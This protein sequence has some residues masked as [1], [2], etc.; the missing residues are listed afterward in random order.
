MPHCETHRTFATLATL[1]RIEVIRVCTVEGTPRGDHETHSARKKAFRRRYVVP[2][3]VYLECTQMISRALFALKS[4]HRTQ[5][6]K[7]SA[8]SMVEFGLIAPIAFLLIFGIIV[9]GLFIMNDIRISNTL[10]DVAR[11]GAICSNSNGAPLNG[12]TVQLPNGA[13]CSDSNFTSYIN[14]QLALIDNSYNWSANT[15]IA[16]YDASGAKV[17]TAMSACSAGYTLVVTTTYQ[18]QLYLPL[19][20]ILFGNPATNTATIHGSGSAT[21]ESQ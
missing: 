14:S 21:C 4:S 18:Q 19:V 7:H 2:G 15:S 3:R 17:G 10:R 12:V 8:Q 13:A 6:G 11:A 9:T 20:G 5:R 1:C 16:V